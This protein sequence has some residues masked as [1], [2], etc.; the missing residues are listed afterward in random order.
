MSSILPNGKSQFID[1]NGR[2][3]IGGS[4]YFYLPNTETPADTWQD[5]DMTIP[6][7]NPV[8]L[9]A[10]GQAVIWGNRRY[11]QILKD[12]D[13][14]QIWDQITEDPNAALTGNMTDNVFVAG[15]D[16]T[17]GVTAQLTLSSH[18]ESIANTW[19]FFDST[20]QAPDQIASIN[21]TTL[22]LT[23]PIPVGV[24]E[25]VVKVG[26]TIAIGT[27]GDGTVTDAKVAP[28]AAIQSSKISFIQTYGGAVRRSVQDKL[29]ERVSIKDF[30]AVGDGVTDDTAAI[31]KA[32]D[33]LA[34]NP[35]KFRLI[36]PTGTYINSG[37]QNWAIQN[38]VVEAEGE[39]HLQYTGT[40]NA[41]VIDGTG[42]PH[43]GC[44][45][46]TFRGFTIDAPATAQNGA[47]IKDVHHSD[48]KLKSRGAGPTYA[49]FKTDGCVCTDMVLECSPNADGGWYQNAMP[50][51]G[52][53]CTGGVG[54][55]TSY[56]NFRNI[57]MEGL[58]KTTVGAGIYLE[59]AFGNNFYGG[60][61]EGC[62]IGIATASNANGCLNNK[63]FG[64]DLEANTD[65]DIFEQG[66]GNEYHSVDTTKHVV[67]VAGSNSC[68]FFGGQH[69]NVEVALG[70][71]A[72][73][74]FG[75]TF[76]RSGVAGT[77]TFTVGDESTVYEGCTDGKTG[78]AGPFPQ[79]GLTVTTGAWTY[80]NTS[81]RPKMLSITGGTVSSISIT[82]G[83]IGNGISQINGLVILAPGDQITINNTAIPNVWAYT[84]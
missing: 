4:V 41:L 27:P 12:A 19:M 63:F 65:H 55:Q 24:Q 22:A 47:F 32:R 52:L 51:Y 31:T 83:G 1:L 44:Y 59:A 16:F 68:K 66:L 25:V 79:T 46:L 76:N 60:T 45:N 77:G 33:A 67:L 20:F 71:I 35:T 8:V 43:A 39:V 40:G 2:P 49:G 70:A 78:K 30:G 28:G 56:C 3:L 80:T 53:W 81:N 7:P 72:N 48:I 13:G 17:P 21:G 64:I 38:A 14:N 37:S 54:A 15:V 9:D 62:T 10:R 73:G 23:A 61:S 50:Q 6:N 42:Q 34:A 11:R 74:F 84:L 75:I 58:A 18:P 29:R 26:T 36:W 5:K 82:R 69:F 57:I